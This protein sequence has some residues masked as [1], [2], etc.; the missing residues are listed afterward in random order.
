MSVT[1]EP[2]A[3]RSLRWRFAGACFDGPS[4]QLTVAGLPVELERRPLELLALLLEHPGEIVTKGEILDALW[5]G[6]VVSEASLTNCMA[7]LRQALGEIGHTAIRTVHGYGYRFA[8]P[9]AV[10]NTGPP[11]HLMLQEAAFAPGG[12]VPHRPNWCLVE[13]LGSGGFGEAW[14]AEQVKSRERRVIKFARDG[15]GAAALRREIALF[16]LLREGLGPRPDLIRVLDWQFAEPPAFIET[17]WAEQGNLAEWAERQGGAAALDLA[18][19]VDIAAQIAEALAAIHGMAV[20]HKDLKPANVLMRTDEAGAPAIVLTDFG[21]GR[22][23]DPASLDAFGITRPDP[24]PSQPDSSGGTQM[25]RAPEL[26]AGGTPSVQADIFALG[27]MLFQLVA[28]D[29]RRPLA[30]GW[31]DLVA[32]PLLREDIAAAAAGDPAR[33]LADAA[34][35]A[36]RLRALPERR[37]ARARAQAAAS[38]AAR[39]RRALELARARRTPLIASLCVL[40]LALATSTTLY[41]RAKRAEARAEAA[42]ARATTVTAF[43]TDDLFSAANPLLGAD[44]NVPVRRLLAVAAAELERRF[45]PGNADRDADRA[46]IEAAIGGAFAGLTDQDDALRLLR[47]ALATLRA[48][49]GEDDPQ[50][51]AVRLAMARL[52]EQ[53]LDRPAMRAAGQAM[54]AAHPRDFATELAARFYIILGGCDSDSEACAAL[55]RPL[56]AESGRRL[57]VRD[58]LT[59]KI[60]A[61]LASRLG[62]ALQFAEAIPMSRALIAETQ[63]VYGPDHLL[64]QERRFELAATLVGAGQVEEAIPILTDVRRRMLALMGGETEMSARVEN[65][66]GMAYYAA[67]RYPES[68]QAFQAAR[69][70]VAARRGESSL[71]V[72]GAENNV[73]NTLAHMGR[74]QDAVA[75]A[76]HV[77]EVKRRAEGPDSPDTLLLERNLAVDFR[78]GGDLPKAEAAYRDLVGRA[79]T[80]MT[81]GEHNLGRWEAEFG[82]LLLN[83]GK[84][85]EA[86][87]LLAEGVATLTKSLGAQ[88]KQTVHAQMVLASVGK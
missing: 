34:D 27:I 84:R 19:R 71:L 20:L 38:E 3:R 60:E 31:E 77:F 4:L 14:L 52:A 40:V 80:I 74:T 58:P 35:L 39:M 54:L 56:A 5:P 26:A 83:E 37:A 2:P 41:V 43:L 45:P 6:R 25:Y 62:D 61:E 12:A 88:D 36:A 78:M 7:R 75:I 18:V 64:V 59:L 48:T 69:D 28:G 42:A 47:P 33:R 49:R 63:R 15:M 65:Q 1:A 30:P 46:V 10:E 73:A 13:R 79:R 67:A 17:V 87:V 68:L 82:E 66:L 72:L 23:L 24:D 86:R 29:V 81:H 22:V 16:R 9:V 8:A 32:D 76:R 57:G 51:Q 11:P 55:L 50:T 85:D 44:P 70:F 53:L 21:S